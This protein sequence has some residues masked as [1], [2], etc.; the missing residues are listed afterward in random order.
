VPATAETFPAVTQTVTQ[1]TIQAYAD[2]SGDYNPLHVDPDFAART[3]FG[4]TIAH[5]P[6][7]LQTFFVAVT[8]WLGREDFPPGATVKVTYRAPV[9]PGDSVTCHA[10]ELVVEADP[11]TFEGECRNQRD[12]TVIGVSATFPREALG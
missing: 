11:V 1:E 7:A 2:L 3:P 10:N 9:R 6:I 4:S 8:Q 12:E 5:G